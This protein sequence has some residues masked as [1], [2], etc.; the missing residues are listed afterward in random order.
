MFPI[1]DSSEV[2][3]DQTV[4]RMTECM[5]RDDENVTCQAVT[6]QINGTLVICERCMEE[7]AEDQQ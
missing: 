6:V 4:I 5:F 1:D 3:S 7:G 2:V